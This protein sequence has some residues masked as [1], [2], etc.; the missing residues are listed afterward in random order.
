MA[1][2][3]QTE[4]TELPD[5]KVKIAATVP[6]DEVEQ[7][8]AHAATRLR[9]RD[10]DA[11]LPQG[12]GAAAARPP[13]GRPRRRHG[14]GA[15]RGAAGVV[16]AGAPR[17]RGD[18]RS[19]TRSSTCPTRPPRAS[20]SSSRSRSAS[21]PT[22]ELGEYKGIEVGKAE[23]EVPAEAIDA[24]IERMRESLA[25]LEH[26]R[27]RRAPTGDYLLIDY[28]GEIDGEEFEG[29]TAYRLPARARL[30]HADR[31]LR[32]GARRRRGGRRARRSRS[33]SPRSTTP[34]TWPAS[35]AT[36]A[37]TV[38]EVRE[39]TLPDLDDDFAADNSDFDTLAEL[40]ADIE[41][42]LEHAF[43]HRAE[44]AFRDAVLDA[45]VENAT[46]EIPEE[47]V[48]ARATEVWERR[49]ALSC[50]ARHG[51][52]D[53]PA[54]PGQD[55]RGG[56]R[57]GPRGRRGRAAPRGRARRGRRGRGRSRS[58]RRRCS[59]RCSRPP[60]R[61]ASPRSCS[62]DCAPRAATALLVEEI[63]MRKAADLVVDS[64]KP[65]AMDAAEAQE[66]LWT[67]EGEGSGRRRGSLDPRRRRLTSGSSRLAVLN[68][69]FGVLQI[70]AVRRRRSCSS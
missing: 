44:H 36:F 48:A 17:L 35:D 31:G 54:D 19:A 3:V 52:R 22:A 14:R 42:R 60:G 37:V 4:I 26:R 10:E 45:A 41:H 15:A 55:S 30:R 18:A 59:R 9:P 38:K 29:G 7:A 65:V 25:G 43:E 51:S 21:G 57:G 20:R 69:C 62:S 53:V 6:A 68:F 8:L 49:R 32:R 23:P 24:E 34:S 50:S 28:A 66:K 46:I 2:S 63:R 70:V 39:K 67:P 5:S 33:P 64:A 27:A 16:R 13:A 56:D 40:R 47:I 12:Q 61:R 11:R 1:A 58:P